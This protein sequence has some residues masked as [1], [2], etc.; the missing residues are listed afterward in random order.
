VRSA[1]A[2]WI[3]A[4]NGV[5]YRTESDSFGIGN[6][7]AVHAARRLDDGDEPV[8]DFKILRGR[9]KEGG[10]ARERTQ[11]LPVFETHD[12]LSAM[13]AL[14]AWVAPVGTRALLYSLGGVRMWKT[15]LTFEGFEEMQTDV[16]KRRAA[17]IAGTSIRLSR[18]FEED[19]SKPPRTFKVWV[20]DDDQ[21]I[22]LK[23]TA[24]TELGDVTARV[25]S[26]ESPDS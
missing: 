12:P 24:H 25:T 20:S 14:R 6:T 11:R 4:D 19:R 21:R 7:L 15:T 16:G 13:L 5:P 2:S 26:Y 10:E 22:P 8:A 18:S 1:I 9:D 23:I 3:D 17:R